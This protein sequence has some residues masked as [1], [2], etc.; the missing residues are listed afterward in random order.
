MFIFNQEKD[1]ESLSRCFDKVPSLYS[2]KRQ[3]EK[4]NLK[5]E[6]KVLK[7]ILWVLDGGNS[8]LKLIT[9]SEEKRKE[10]SCLQQSGNRQAQMI[11]EVSNNNSHRWTESASDQQTFW[12][13]HGSRL[14]NLYSILNYGLQQH[15]S[16]TGLFGEGIYLC[17]DLGVSLT[18]SSQ[19][20]GWKHS[21]LGSNIS[22]VVLAEVIDHD[23]VKVY[24][25]D[26]DK[27]KVEG[28][29]GGRVPDKYVVVRNNELLH[30][31][32][33]I[34]YI[35]FVIHLPLSSVNTLQGNTLL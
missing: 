16:K 9:L 22:G 15:L 20:L 2:L 1:V 32:L 24:S 35:T 30:I 6:T 31:R 26:K 8:S 17:E 11:L 14:D 18:Y 19:G 3:L 4:G 29:I 34:L 33:V 25:E 10:I 23:D 7:L 5:L 13:F 27:G 21:G 12:A 28:S